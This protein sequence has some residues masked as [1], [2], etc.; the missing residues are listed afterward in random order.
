MG[1]GVV[2]TDPSPSRP[3]AGSGVTMEYLDN[4]LGSRPASASDAVATRLGAKRSSCTDNAAIVHSDKVRSRNDRA[5]R[6]TD[7][8]G[9]SRREFNGE[10]MYDHRVGSEYRYLVATANADAI[11]RANRNAGGIGR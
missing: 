9:N 4:V 11:G 7:G 8:E 1:I 10:M 3:T 5:N 2:S 6:I